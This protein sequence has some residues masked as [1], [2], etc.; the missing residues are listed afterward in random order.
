MNDDDITED[1]LLR[2][3]QDAL[4]SEQGQA[5]FEPGAITRPALRR[6]FCLSLA[7][8]DRILENMISGGI[9]VRDWVTFSDEWGATQRIKGYRL[10]T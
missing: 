10:I 4:Q 7:Q 9:I 3:I 6:Q 5:G 1:D 8:A 2:A